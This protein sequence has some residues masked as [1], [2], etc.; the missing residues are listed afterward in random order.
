[1]VNTVAAIGAG[2]IGGAITKCLLGAAKLV[3]EGVLVPSDI[4]EMVTTSGAPPSRAYTRSRTG[5]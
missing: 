3:M 2:V 5:S 1:M 4:E